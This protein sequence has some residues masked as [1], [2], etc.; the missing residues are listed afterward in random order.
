M[1]V[2]DHFLILVNSQNSQ[3]MQEP[4]FQSKIFDILKEDYQKTFKKLTWLF[5]LH[6]V[7]FYGQDYSKQKESGTRLQP[8]FK[9][10]KI[11]FLVTCQLGNFDDLIQSGF[12]LALKIT[13]ANLYKL[14]PDLIIIPD[15]SDL[16]NLE[17]V[18]KKILNILRTKRVV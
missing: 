6:T 17:Y 15:S 8:L 12:W 2:L 18:K 3:C 11:S 16:F 1:L 7:P 9:L 5:P 4:F 14:I 13:N 10:Q